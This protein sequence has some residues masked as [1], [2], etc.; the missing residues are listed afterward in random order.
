MILVIL[1]LLLTKGMMYVKKDA[2][3]F[4][5]GGIAYPAI[6]LLW[7]GYSHYSMA[8]AG[9]ACMILINRLCCGKLKT[10][11]LFVKCAAGSGIITSV[12]LFT[13]LL[14]NKVFSMNIWDYSSLPY[15]IFGQI[16]LPFS[17]IWFL[18]SIPA[19]YLC[20][21][22]SRAV[23]RFESYTPSDSFSELGQ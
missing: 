23:D 8:I 1:L 20:D 13:G 15:N 10:K 21:T 9:G 18:M 12:E 14:F 19:V 5:V 6:E 11:K 4:I 22:L 7:R 2:Y 17:L 3:F 16:C